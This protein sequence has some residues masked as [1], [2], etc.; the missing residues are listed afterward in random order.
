MSYI[1]AVKCQCSTIR[2]G[3]YMLAPCCLKNVARF[4]SMTTGCSVLDSGI[5]RYNEGQAQMPECVKI[6]GRS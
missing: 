2:G 5:N 6:D 1:Y 4:C 3:V